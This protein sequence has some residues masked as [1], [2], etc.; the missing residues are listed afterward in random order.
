MQKNKTVNEVLN[1]K[2]WTLNA[3]AFDQN[4]STFCI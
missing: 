4:S 1:I 3:K 2:H